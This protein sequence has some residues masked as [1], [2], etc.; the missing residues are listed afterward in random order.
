[1]QAFRNPRGLEKAEVTLLRPFHL[2]QRWSLGQSVLSLYR[3]GLPA[4]P[5]GS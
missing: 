3:R 1:M 4:Q 2:V 5:A